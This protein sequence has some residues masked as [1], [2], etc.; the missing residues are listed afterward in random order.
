MHSKYPLKKSYT[1]FSPHTH[2]KTF[3]TLYDFL[4]G[5]VLPL[6]WVSKTFT[7]PKVPG[8]TGLLR[9]CSQITG[10]LNMNKAKKMKPDLSFR[11]H[12]LTL[13]EQI[14]R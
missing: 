11:L 8:T 9:S 12:G 3:S 7:L 14:P 4:V 6:I 13:L 10:Q 2:T 1:P 5:L